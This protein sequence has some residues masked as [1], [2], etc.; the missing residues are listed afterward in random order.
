MSW[1]F[2][3]QRARD[4][5]AEHE[6]EADRIHLARLYDQAERDAFRSVP[7]A[8]PSAERSAARSSPS[9]RP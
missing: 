6:R 2:Q 7:D 4:I 1:Y 5:I 8:P 9:G 3:H